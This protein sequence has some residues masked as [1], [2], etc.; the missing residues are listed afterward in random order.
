[1]NNITLAGE[2]SNITVTGEKVKFIMAVKRLSGTIDYLYCSSGIHIMNDV[3][4]GEKITCYGEVR[5]ANYIGPD[6]KSHLRV[7]VHVHTIAPYESED[8]NIVTVQGFI[9]K[10]PNYRFT[11]YNREICDVI[12]A[13]NRATQGSDYLPCIAWSRHAKRMAKLCVGEGVNIKG[14]LQ[15]REYEKKHEDGVVE[16]KT[17]YE[18]SIIKFSKWGGSRENVG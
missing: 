12:I 6:G 2:V 18:I 8:K 16:I 9:C 17:A 11:P 1:M 4:N 13:S 3:M 5:T 7:Y 14:R 10:D 15:S